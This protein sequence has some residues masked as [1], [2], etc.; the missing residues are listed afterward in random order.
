[1]LIGPDV[2]ECVEL[3]I[4]CGPEKRCFN[5][6]GDFQ[7]VDVTCPDNYKRDTQTGYVLAYASL[8][9]TV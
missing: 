2:D 5:G 7:C 6:R 3:N 9:M 8:Y 1:M 4:S